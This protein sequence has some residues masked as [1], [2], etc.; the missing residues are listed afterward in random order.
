MV[1]HRTRRHKKRTPRIRRRAK[2]GAIPGT[3]LAPRD[4]LSPRITLCTFDRNQVDFQEIDSV[5]ALKSTVDPSRVTWV[6]VDGLGDAQ[7]IKEL[8]Q[9]FSLHRL[10]LED[11]V[12]VHQRAKVEDYENHLFIV[13]RMVSYDE[14]LQSEQISLFL[15]EHFVLTLQERVGD[16]L[17][18]VR[19]RLRRGHGRIRQS[20]A[21]YLAYAIID[22][23][24]DSYFPVVDAAAEQLEVLDEEI[25]EGDG[26]NSIATL[27]D[28]RQ[29]L[30][31]LRRAIRPARDA[32]SRLVSDQPRL[33]GRETQLYIRD[34]SDHAVQLIDLLETYREMCTGLR[35]LQMSTVN[36]RMNEIMKVLTIIAT[37]FIPLSFITG[38]YGMN[39][40]TSHAWNMPE[41]KQPFGYP[42]ALAI[43][44]FLAGGMVTFFW[45]KGWIGGRTDRE[46][47]ARSQLSE[48]ARK[49]EH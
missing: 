1:L 43:M 14:E 41:L 12:N 5:D 4:A 32:L 10:A 31:L 23:V 19:E 35:D 47:V 9:T 11:A 25:A 33:I 13:L 45:R 39:F 26:A 37:I 20:G 42:V 3:I 38:L 8:G 2:P 18:P 27:H 30:L 7:V 17:D 29:D 16:C 48:P 28:V 49:E 40:D 22:A 21:D 34:C 46:R 24:I 36:N 44:S 15:G 6:N